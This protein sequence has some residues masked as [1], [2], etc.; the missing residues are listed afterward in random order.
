VRC[1]STACTQDGTRVQAPID[2]GDCT[3]PSGAGVWSRIDTGAEP[4]FACVVDGAPA[5]PAAIA[6][7][8]D[9]VHGRL[10]RTQAYLVGAGLLHETHGGGVLRGI[11]DDSNWEVCAT[12]PSAGARVA[13]REKVQL[14]VDRSC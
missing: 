7:M 9:V 8:P 12:S 14:F 4:L 13:P 2:Q 10:D 5:G 11:I 6:R 1:S 3:G